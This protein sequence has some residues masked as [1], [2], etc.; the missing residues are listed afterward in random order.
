MSERERINESAKVMSIALIIGSNQRC[1]YY[2]N[3]CALQ[4]FFLITSSRL[5]DL[6]TGSL[7]PF[8]LTKSFLQYLSL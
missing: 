3:C 4:Y 6:S 1:N 2:C 7:L 5:I 8:D